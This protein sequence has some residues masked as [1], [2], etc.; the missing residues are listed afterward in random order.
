MKTIKEKLMFIPATGGAMFKDPQIF[1]ARMRKILLTI[2][3]GLALSSVTTFS[4]PAAGAGMMMLHGHVSAVVSKLPPKGQLPATTNLNLALGLSLRNREALTNL[5]QQLY[6]PAS[7]NYHH[8][9][10]PEEFTA[11]FGPTEQDYQAVINFARAS[12][13]T[14]TGTHP[15]RMLLDVSGQ[16]ADIER[17]LH[18]TLRIYK[19]PTEARDFFAPDV[20]PSV[21]AGLSIQDISGLD[22]Y[23]RPHPKYKIKPATQPS[24]AT[25]NATPNAGSGPYGNYLGNDF[26]NAYVPGT[27]LNGSGQTIALVQFDGY[28]GNDI[29]AYETMAG[30]TNIPLRN[31]LIDGFSGAPTGNGGEVEVSL[32]IEM[33]VSMAPALAQ[34]V[35]YEGDPYNFHPNDVL[36]RIATDNSARQISC[37]WGWTGGPS[38]T[39]GQIFQQMAVQG[40]TFFTASGDSDAYPAGTVDS[41]YN[42]G[43]PSDSPYLTSVGGTTLTMSRAGGSW[44]SETVWNWGLVYGSAYDGVGS[45]GGYSSYYPIPSWQATVSMTLNQGSTTNRN[46]PDVALTADNVYVVADGG[47]GYNGV[48]GTSCAAPL[49][50]GFTALVN[51]QATNNG[52]AAVGF[53]NPA[54]YAIA[55]GANYSACFHDITTGNN[56]WSGSP[57]L[58]YAVSGYDLCTGLGTPNTNLI[59]ALAGTGGSTFTHISPPPP[60]YGTALSALNGGNPNGTWELFVQDDVIEDS[61]TNYNGWI[62]TLTTASPVGQTADLALGPPAYTN[63]VAPGSTDTFSITI[64]NCGPSASI[65]I[66]VRDTLPNGFTFVSATPAVTRNGS[67]L[68]W[69]LGNFDPD[70]GTNLTLTLT[71]PTNSVQGLPYNYAIS[72]ADTSDGNPADDSAYVYFIVAS[73]A[74]PQ[75]SGSFMSANGTFHLTV[76][77]QSGQEYIVQASTNLLFNWVPVYT[78]PSPFVSPFTFTDLNASIYPDRFYRVVTGP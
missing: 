56:T 3:L 38:A 74:R 36:N 32:D 28:Y 75:L 57:T 48:G 73:S 44:S 65:N 69:A 70:T 72:S 46:F 17:A 14:V 68:T 1:A 62:L 43:A 27:S 47:V 41:P 66:V 52:L 61:G 20:D 35:V 15:N 59:S 29:V 18:V 78:N 19:H 33:S 67:Q 50:A 49:W 21:P 60:P 58:F 7:L 31:V 6:D 42:F 54:I 23:R 24:S 22:N 37:S 12:G 34:I 16:A 71:A 45:S 25:A 2:G 76:N 30:R 26:R 13:L 10:T 8:Y 5:L 4:S 64:T 51:Q 77:G 9:L 11:Q 39:T 63:T 40:Q 55:K 53:I